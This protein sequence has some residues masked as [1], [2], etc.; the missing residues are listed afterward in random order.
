VR[1]GYHG[2]AW[3]GVVGHPVGVTSIKDLFYVTPGDTLEAVRRVGEYGWEGIE[4]FD[5]NLLEYA[6]DLDVL[7]RALDRAELALVGVYSGANL[8]YDDVLE[9]ELWRV[10]RACELGAALDAEHFVIGG[11]AQRSRMPEEADYDRLGSAL[12]RV[13]AI[14][15]EHGLVPSFH[16]HLST[17]VEGPEQV[18]LAFART[19]IGFCPDLAHLQAAGGDPV[20]L[21]RR[22][23]DRIPYVHFKDVDADGNFVP[24][25]HGIVDLEG[26]AGALRESGFDG[27][28][29]VELD[30]YDGDPDAAARENLDRLRALL[31]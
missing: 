22:Y 8:I 29:L 15:E 6:D 9:D 17:I 25:G 18:D 4:L 27:W 28:A 20:D 12:D 21:V 19:R 23:A 13:A 30:G 14:A 1:F 5:G 3:G 7:R 2:N 16:P 10:R 26:V 31:G 11:G 24:L